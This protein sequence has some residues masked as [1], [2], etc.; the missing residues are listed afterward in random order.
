MD[1]EEWA[2]VDKD[3]A[4]AVAALFASLLW[5]Y[6]TRPPGHR[7]LGPV[8]MSQLSSPPHHA[9]QMARG[10]FR[11]SLTCELSWLEYLKC[12]LGSVARVRGMTRLS[13]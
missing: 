2:K 12:R 6:R 8:F 5:N 10:G 7:F 11:G 13:N 1:V 3:V 9:W 4:V